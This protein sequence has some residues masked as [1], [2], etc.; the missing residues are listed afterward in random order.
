M[1]QRFFRARRKIVRGKLHRKPELLKL[2]WRDA[3]DVAI[4]GG[5]LRH[6]FFQKKL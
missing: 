1:K 5:S 2:F 6:Q 4:T 3:T